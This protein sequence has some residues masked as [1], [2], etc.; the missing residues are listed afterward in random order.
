MEQEIK[1]EVITDYYK[2][3]AIS[4][5]SMKTID[6]LKGG[7]PR[8]FRE[9]FDTIEEE[10]EKPS[11]SLERG[12]LIHLYCENPK[13]FRVLE[14]DKPSEKAGIVADLVIERLQIQLS[15]FEEEASKNEL[16]LEEYIKTIPDE[17]FYD[18]LI[19]GAEIASYY[20]NW[21]V[22]AKL[23]N[24]KITI[25]YIKQMLVTSDP[26]LI[27]LDKKTKEVIDG[28]I[29][30]LEEHPLASKLLFAENGMDNIEYL[31]EAEIYWEETLIIDEGFPITLE[32][33]GKL[34]NVEIN[35]NTKTIIMK[36]IKSTVNPVYSYAG[37]EDKDGPFQHYDTA[38][39]MAWYVRAL[40]KLIKN[41]NEY[42]IEV[43]IIAVQT[44]GTFQTVVYKLNDI[45]LLNGTS[46]YMDI[47]NRIA[48]HKRLD[49]WD[50]S[51][52]EIENNGYLII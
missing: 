52:E 20:P 48:K 42:K 46:S 18:D 49:R 8:K 2:I 33:K 41:I 47:L 25:P 31:K 26:S 22:D 34:D 30:S 9:F 36:D 37:N 23:K 28:A 21:G 10:K 24:L 13:Q 43:Y 1:T 6:P 27:C 5:S 29:K 17:Q 4:A 39:Q 11:K 40:S 14:I 16:S 15:S 7:N 12:S 45:T 35:H 32:C 44:T 50:M 19:A 3:D 51:L 38:R